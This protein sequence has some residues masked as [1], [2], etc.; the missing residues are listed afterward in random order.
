[1]ILLY[2]ASLALATSTDLD[3]GRYWPTPTD[4]PGQEAAAEA[5]DELLTQLDG[6]EVSLDWLKKCFVPVHLPIPPDEAWYARLAQ[7]LGPD[8]A[9]GQALRKS[10]GAVNIVDGPD[11]TRVVMGGTPLLSLVIRRSTDGAVVIDGIEETSCALCEEPSRFVRDLIVNVKA[12]GDGAHRLLPTVE[13]EVATHIK[14]NP[15]LGSGSRWVGMLQTRNYTG[16]RLSWL[17]SRAEVVGGRGPA[18]DVVYADGF[19]D[20]WKVVYHRGRWQIDYTALEEDSPLRLDQGEMTSIF[21]TATLAASALRHWEPRWTES[22]DETHLI[23]GQRAIGAHV[24]PRDGTIL[25]VLLDLDR[26]LCGIVRVDPATHTVVERIRVRPPDPRT[27]I[28]TGAWYSRWRTALS[29]DGRHLALALPSRLW[30]VGLSSGTNELMSTINGVTALTF[31]E[32]PAN[33]NGP[34]L[35]AAWK[36]RLEIYYKTGFQTYYLDETPNS[37]GANRSTIFATTRQGSL[38]EFPLDGSEPL[39]RDVCCEERAIDA[40][41]HPMGNEVLV[42]CPTECQVAAHRVHLNGPIED[43]RGAGVERRGTSWSPDGSFFIT[44]TPPNEPHSLLL[45]NAAENRP[46]ASFGSA[47]VHTISWAPDAGWLVTTD[48]K[49]QVL[50]WDVART[51]QRLGLR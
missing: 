28:D 33:E 47:R 41:V 42:V 30:L 6:P 16:D 20:S 10:P 17:L 21:D 40:S 4:P 26:V 48:D 25:V 1:M 14:S 9:L 36:G 31:A 29:P 39:A 38:I 18:V 2:A 50:L 22:A 11:Y 27:N 46:I 37:L 12:N 13:L 32:P 23:I 8:G 49:G 7:A 15:R 24:D 35:A 45:W 44:A 51:R 3:E 43:A 19:V 34:L 5:V